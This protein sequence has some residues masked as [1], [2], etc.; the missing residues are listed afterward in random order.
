MLDLVDSLVVDCDDTFHRQPAEEGFFQ[1]LISDEKVQPLSLVHF[2]TPHWLYPGEE[3]T[4]SFT[5]MYRP[6][7]QPGSKVYQER[8]TKL[9]VM[10]SRFFQTPPKE[11][12]QPIVNMKVHNMKVQILVGP[13]TNS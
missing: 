1:T 2:M 3:P 6:T 10:Y 4:H 12:A 7:W 9:L 13:R 11:N 8:H 5:P